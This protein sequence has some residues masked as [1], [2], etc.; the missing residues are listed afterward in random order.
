[1][2]NVIFKPGTKLP[3]INGAQVTWSSL[4]ETKVST[5]QIHQE[6]SSVSSGTI[7]KDFYERKITA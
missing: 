4:N 5:T 7:T 6:V 2:Q 1:M 3:G